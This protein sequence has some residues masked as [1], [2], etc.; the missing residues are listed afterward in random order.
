[1]RFPFIASA[2]LLT[3][4]GCAG[5]ERAESDTAVPATPSTSASEDRARAAATVANAIAA[6]PAGADS[7]LKAAGYTRDTFQTMMYEIAADSAM[8]VAYAVAKGR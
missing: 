3:V 2:V 1:M 7:I 5:G 4:I 8:S 6:N